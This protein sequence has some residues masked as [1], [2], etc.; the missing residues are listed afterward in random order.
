M[1]VSRAGWHGASA[2]T[3]SNHLARELKSEEETVEMI[4]LQ[5][6]VL[7]Q[8]VILALAVDTENAKISPVALAHQV[9]GRRRAV[10]RTTSSRSTIAA[11]FRSARFS[12]LFSHATFSWTARARALQQQQQQQQDQSQSSRTSVH[13]KLNRASLQL[14]ARELTLSR[15]DCLT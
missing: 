1:P 5:Y 14:S 8:A 7:A 13:L 15:Q 10:S 12:S 2:W 6:Q 9:S 4:A 3:E 11:F